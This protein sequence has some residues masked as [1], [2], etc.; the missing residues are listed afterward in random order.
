M[1]SGYLQNEGV[2]L[3]LN[4]EGWFATRD[5][6]CWD[7]NG[8][9]CYKGRKDLLFRCG[10]EFVSPEEIEREIVQ[11]QGIEHVVVVP[12]EDPEYGKCPVALLKLMES[13]R[14][15]WEKTIARVENRLRECLP[16]HKRPRAYLP[17][18]EKQSPELKIN[19]K[20]LETYANEVYPVR[21]SGNPK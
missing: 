16:S 9:L 10:G 20:E 15:N 12:S 4:T 5:L 21:G 18:P 7:Q 19:R 6:G 11:I 17:L 2:H 1:F 8:R 14:S 13:Q 3:P